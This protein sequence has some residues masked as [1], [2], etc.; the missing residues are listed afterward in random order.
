[1]RWRPFERFQIRTGTKRPDLILCPYV[2]SNRSA[3]KRTPYDSVY[4]VGIV[5]QHSFRISPKLG[6]RNSFLPCWKGT[7]ETDHRGTVISVTA[8]M[9]PVAVGF[10]AF[11]AGG[12]LL[13]FSVS[14]LRILT[15]LGTRGTLGES[16]PLLGILGVAVVML[17]MLEGMLYIGFWR[18]EKRA[19]RFLEQL[20]QKA[21]QK[22]EQEL[23]DKLEQ[24]QT[25]QLEYYD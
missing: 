18:E 24:I 8:G 16:S 19:R 14:L 25:R 22:A 3:G 21:D 2:Q 20:C 10:C 11:W 6:Y 1:M 12:V 5:D 23:P 13:A 7:F 9:H 15:L 17:L 4:F